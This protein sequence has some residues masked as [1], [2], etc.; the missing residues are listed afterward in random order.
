M[1]FH[2]SHLKKRWLFILRQRF[3]YGICPVIHLFVTVEP[4]GSLVPVCGL[5]KR[6][7]IQIFYLAHIGELGEIIEYPGHLIAVSAA[8]IT[9][10]PAGQAST[11]EVLPFSFPISH[12][13]RR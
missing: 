2:Q 6:I 13:R 3:I 12:A 5:R 11:S 4:H 1:N 9:V 10:D 8:E 7:I